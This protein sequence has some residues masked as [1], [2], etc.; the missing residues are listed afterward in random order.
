MLGFNLP[1]V[2]NIGMKHE[3]WIELS[4]NERQDIWTWVYDRLAF[5][6]SVHDKDFPGFDEPAPSITYSH[7]A[8]WGENFDALNRDLHD[9][10]FE[11]FQQVI[12]PDEFLYALDWQHRCYRFFP[13]R[14]TSSDVS[15][16]LIPVLPDGDYYIFL[17]SS[18][19][20]GW[21][22][23]PWEQTICV[24]GQPLLAKVSQS[25]PQI[26][27]DPLRQKRED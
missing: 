24:Y 12:R 10:A 21:L 15:D 1:L 17:E 8:I 4:K 7:V 26:F 20:F 23:H 19:K 22:G 2:Q 3:A 27:R 13:H 6:P 14:A 18:F 9:K 5:K 16:W 11:I 25:R